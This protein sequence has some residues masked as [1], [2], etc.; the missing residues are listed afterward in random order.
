MTVDEIAALVPAWNASRPRFMTTLRA[1]VSP[2]VDGAAVAAYL[3][4]DFDLDGAIGVQL[5]AVGIRIG[6][7]RDVR[8]PIPQPW[9]AF[10]DPLRGFGAGVWKGPYSGTFGVYSLDDDTYRR[11]LRA[12]IIAKRWDGTVPGAQA[13]FDAF[14]ID[15][16][17]HVFVQDNAQVANP[18]NYFSFGVEGQG[19]GE[20]LWFNGQALLSAVGKVD[21]SM[22]IAVSGKMPPPILLGLMA[23]GAIPIKPGGVQTKYAVTTVDRA[24]LFGFGVQ[25]EFVSGFGVG[26][27]GAPPEYVLVNY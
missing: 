13:A 3:P 21:V 9:F 7:S 27:W 8:I 19:F 12:N 1:T 25:N 2:F 14:F 6:R 24:P 26:A 18:Y 15:P 16:D 17:T 11:L 22:T 10:S 5:D 23:Q 4:L 20:G